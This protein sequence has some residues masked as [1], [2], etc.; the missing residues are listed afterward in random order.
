[1]SLASAAIR[2]GSAVMSTM[3]W[4]TARL[5]VASL[6]ST[7]WA[8]AQIAR[9]STLEERP[10]PQRSANLGA[11]AHRASSTAPCPL[12]ADVRQSNGTELRLAIDHLFA[13]L[14]LQAGER[15]GLPGSLDFDE[16]ALIRVA[17]R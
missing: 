13:A 8:T 17:P 2:A 10:A 7:R 6:A 3:A 4:T 11:N 12:L 9:P 5:Y 16:F 14:A 1:M 15:W